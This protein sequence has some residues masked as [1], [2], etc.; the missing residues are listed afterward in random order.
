MM[1]LGDLGRTLVVTTVILVGVIAFA[2]AIKPLAEGKIGPADALRLTMLLSVPMLQF[3]LPFAAGFSATLTYHR[4]AADNEAMASSAGGL[5]YGSLLAP[6]ALI[7]LAL[8]LV[9]AVLSNQLIPSFLR[10]AEQLVQRDITRLM[11]MPIKQ[12]RS[13]RLGTYDIYADQAVG[14]MQADPS[15][16]ALEHLVLFGVIAVNADDDNAVTA[17]KR[18]DVW[19]FEDPSDRQGTAVQFRFSGV[20]SGSEGGAM[21]QERTVTKR[22]PIPLTVS[23]DPKFLSFADMQAAR[24]EPRRIHEVDVKARALAAGL[25][26]ERMIESLRRRVEL[27]GRAVLEGPDARLSVAADG[28]VARGDG[29]WALQPR[30]DASVIELTARTTGARELVQRASSAVLEEEG[31]DAQIGGGP[32]GAS[33]F[34]LGLTDVVTIDPD[35]S[36]VNVEIESQEYTRLQPAGLG[37]DPFVGSTLDELLA[38]AD[39]VLARGSDQSARIEQLRNAAMERNAE[40]QR[41][42]TSKL[43]ERAAYSVACLI[44]VVSGA[45]I[46]LRLRESLPLPVYLWS[47]FP[48]LFAVITISTGQRLTYQQGAAGLGLLWGGVA[49]LCVLTLAQFARL[50][51]H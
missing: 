15:T 51:R 7:G 19:L 22:F 9:L 48:A 24:L 38:S 45:I 32:G 35:G 31:R 37:P 6:A 25:E 16:G 5:G 18:V 47:F 2:G 14:P 39:A 26:L 44:M 36:G 12:G 13:I 50:R 23:D 34:S 8:S 43:H 28:L 11:V 30:P 40:M 49:L 1:L 42:L 46:A 29:A 27:E 33:T 10:S 3:A 20:W 41:E 4:F 17:A 21:R